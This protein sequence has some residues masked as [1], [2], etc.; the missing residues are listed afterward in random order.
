[1]GQSCSLPV[2]GGCPGG[3]AGARL[4]G[5]WAPGLNN[6]DDHSN[7][8]RGQKPEGMSGHHHLAGALHCSTEGA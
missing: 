1:M 8:D 3:V 7:S 6:D 2:E 5:H 4:H